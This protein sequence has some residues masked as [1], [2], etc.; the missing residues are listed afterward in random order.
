MRWSDLPADSSAADAAA[1]G[2]RRAQ[3]E[4]LRQ[5]LERLPAGHPSSPD[6]DGPQDEGPDDDG[7][8]AEGLD[9]DGPP[10]GARGTAQAP[11]GHDRDQ[12]RPDEPG[13]GEGSARPGRPAG[14]SRP[15]G[16]DIR[17][18]GAGGRGD[19]YRPWFASG[20]PGEPWFAADG[21]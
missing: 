1:S 19:Q 3:W 2:L 15:G 10:D 8:L 14:P 16:G 12:D 17:P 21:Q 7:P 11:E 6:D 18:A 20:E 13:R 4:Q 5:R 9:D